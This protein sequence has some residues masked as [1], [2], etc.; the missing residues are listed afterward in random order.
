MTQ[1]PLGAER[2]QRIDDILGW[3]Y[4]LSYAVLIGVVALLFF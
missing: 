2:V 1:R 3:A 4:P